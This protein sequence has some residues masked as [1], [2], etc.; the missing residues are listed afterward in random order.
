MGALLDAFGEWWAQH[1]ETVAA[2]LDDHEVAPQL[3]LMAFLQRVVNG[4]A[5]EIA[6]RVDREYGI[7]RGAIDLLVRWP[8]PDG[9]WQ[10]EGIEL[11]V[12]HDKK[13]DPI[14]AGLDQLDGDLTRL[15]LATGALVVFDRRTHRPPIADR[16]HH[17]TTTSP[18][19]RAIRV[20]RA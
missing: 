16:L 4:G 14:D 18:A 13:P 11:K 3:V 8:L 20:L 9:T 5:Q 6:G 15:G 17:T 7:G 12:W 1:G 10:R 2:R 19:G